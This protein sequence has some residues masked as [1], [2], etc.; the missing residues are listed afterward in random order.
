MIPFD[1]IELHHHR[2]A[3]RIAALR[4]SMHWPPY[5][6]R[7]AIGSLLVAAGTRIAPEAAPSPRPA[8]PCSVQASA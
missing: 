7:R 2:H 8:A 4:T 6:I 5:G 3:D 1:P